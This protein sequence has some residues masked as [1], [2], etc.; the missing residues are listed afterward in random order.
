MNE[1]EEYMGLDFVNHVETQSNVEKEPIPDLQKEHWESMNILNFMADDFGEHPVAPS[2]IKIDTKKVKKQV[3]LIYQNHNIPQQILN[4]ENLETFL[5]KIFKDFEPSHVFTPELVGSSR[6]LED[7][8]RNQ[9]SLSRLPRRCKNDKCYLGQH[10]KDI[11]TA[12]K[13]DFISAFRR[14][15]TYCFCGE[16][17]Q[18]GFVEN[19]KEKWVGH[20]T[21]RK[22]FQ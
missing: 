4:Q 8:E 18:Y 3:K 14:N 21:A 15:G 13:K 20:V 7:E 1:N 10:W 6:I 16:S 5:R 19:G 22:K 2:S 17:I 11:Q 12:E 9:K